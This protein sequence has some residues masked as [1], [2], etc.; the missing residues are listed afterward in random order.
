MQ[1]N[2][3]LISRIVTW[4]ILGVLAVVG[5][6]LALQLLGIVTGVLGAV[7]GVAG[8]LL[9]TVGPIMLAGWLAMKAW[10]AFSKQPAA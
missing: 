4:T 7:F 2:K 5:I 1:E 8:F 3:S 10:K 9:F 6:R